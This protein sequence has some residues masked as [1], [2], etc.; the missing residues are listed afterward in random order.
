MWLFESFLFL[1]C[2]YGHARTATHVRART[3]GHARTATYVRPRMYGHARAKERPVWLFLASGFKVYIYFFSF[4]L[5][6]RMFLAS[7]YGHVRAKER[8]VSLLFL[9]RGLSFCFLGGACAYGHTPTGTHLRACTSTFKSD[10]ERMQNIEVEIGVEG[11][12][13]MFVKTDKRSSI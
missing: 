8:P 9:A 3:Y 11:R 2:T 1:V 12:I 13:Q 7:M 10:R 4:F 6:V 5:H